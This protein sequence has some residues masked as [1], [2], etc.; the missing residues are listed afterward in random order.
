MGPG[1]ALLAAG[2][3]RHTLLVDAR[4]AVHACGC[5]SSGQLGTGLAADEHKPVALA[6]LGGQLVR[7]A[8][9]GDAHSVLL[10]LDGSC[11]PESAVKRA[12]SLGWMSSVLLVQAPG[13]DVVEVG[14][15]SSIDSMGLVVSMVSAEDGAAIAD[16]VQSGREAFYAG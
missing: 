8:A 5:G 14:A 13:Q 15:T 10:T 12:S 6:S 11:S 4:G 1:D 2:G 9:A 16:A 7:D 3:G